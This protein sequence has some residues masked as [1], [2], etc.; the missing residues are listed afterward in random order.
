MYLKIAEKEKNNF[1][2]YLAT[3]VLVIFG[4]F[5]AQ[6]PLTIALLFKANSLGMN[7]QEIESALKAVDFS[8]FEIDQN[9][10]LLL[11]LLSF[12]FAF[13]FLWLG[14]TKIHKKDFKDLI[15]ASEKINWSKIFFAFALWFGLT[16]LVEAIFYFQNPSNY[17]FQFQFESFFV[18]AIIAVF[19]LPIQTSF[20]ELFFRGYLLQGISLITKHRWIPLLVTSILFGAMHLM[21]P[22]V[23]AFGLTKMMIYYVG[24]GAFLCILT[25]LD[26]SLE[27][28]LGVHAA[29]N[30]YGALMVTF[31]SSAMQTAAIF[32]M[33]EVDVNLMLIA[34][35]VA[36]LVFFVIVVKK[37]NLNDWTKVFGKVHREEYSHINFS[38]SPEAERDN[39]NI[40]TV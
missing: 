10:I 5:F 7:L 29:T 34:F 18:L 2:I 26:D 28:A 30:I 1:G 9:I 15:T 11:V 25:L 38:I 33:K 24:V 8:V 19:L 22:E 20:E 4:Y 32:K 21:N 35:A 17:Q 12:L 23:A 13:F 16:L 31:D 27:L 14:Q 40:N 6:I 37:Y 3:I 39:N 36:C